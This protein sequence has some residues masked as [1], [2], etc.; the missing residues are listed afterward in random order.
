MIRDDRGFSLVELMIVTVIIGML[1]MIA[2]PL[3]DEIRHASYEAVL[4][5][6]LHKVETAQ[7]MFFVEHG[8][9]ADRL[10][11]LDY[12]PTRDVVVTLEVE[13]AGPPDEIGEGPPAWAGDDDGAGSS[14]GWSAHARYGGTAVECAIFTGGAAP[15]DPADRPGVVACETG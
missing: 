10:G 11:E 14:A 2:Y 8:R 9:Y 12:R 5:S 1:A 3:L 13:D 6:D 4:K 7:E 15:A